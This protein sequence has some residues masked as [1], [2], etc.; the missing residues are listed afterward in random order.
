MRRRRTPSTVEIVRQWGVSLVSWLVCRS[1]GQ[2]LV[3]S[4]VVRLV[5]WLVGQVL[6]QYNM[7]APSIDA[8]VLQ[9][10]LKRQR[11]NQSP[12]STHTQKKEYIVLVAVIFRNADD[13]TRKVMRLSF[14]MRYHSCVGTNGG[15]RHVFLHHYRYLIHITFIF[16]PCFARG[17]DGT[18]AGK[19][20]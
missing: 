8:P 3:G 20:I 10:D 1:V 12:A 14:V 19:G 11:E 7:R 4:Q 15:A 13:V 18:L 2:R 6:E 9:A 16:Y 5:P 17:G